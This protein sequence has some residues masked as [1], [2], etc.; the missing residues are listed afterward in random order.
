MDSWVCRWSSPKD[1]GLFSKLIS[2]QRP[3]GSLPWRQQEPHGKRGGGGSQA[4]LPLHAPITAMPWGQGSACAMGTGSNQDSTGEASGSHCPQRSFQAAGTALSRCQPLLPLPLGS[5]PH[6]PHGSAISGIAPRA[7]PSPAATPMRGRSIAPLPR[8]P[9]HPPPRLCIPA[10]AGHCSP[11]SLQGSLFQSRGRGKRSPCSP[12]FLLCQPGG[13][14][15]GRD[16]HCPTAIYIQ[17]E[18]EEEEEEPFK[19]GIALGL[20]HHPHP[21]PASAPSSCCPGRKGLRH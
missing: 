5:L 7:L 9:F 16:A 20:T 12:A 19:A 21:R 17:K 8:H 4:P 10:L 1:E 15:V 13:A 3:G 2:T 6:W 18:E 14:G 11:S